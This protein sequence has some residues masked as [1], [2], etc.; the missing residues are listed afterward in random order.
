MK[1]LDGRPIFGAPTQADIPGSLFDLPIQFV[2]GSNAGSDG[3]WVPADAHAFVGDWS[4]AMVGTRAGIR[5][6]IFDQG[7][8]TD[9]A[10]NVVYSLMESDMVALRVTCRYAFK[11]FAPDTADGETLASDEKY[12]FALVKPA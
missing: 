12:P 6:R 3:F 1:D 9:G 10:G 7:V 4:Q 11:V 5:Y 8:I 2:K